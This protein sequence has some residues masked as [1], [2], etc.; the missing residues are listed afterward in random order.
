M[1]RTLI[2]VLSLAVIGTAI[3]AIVQAQEAVPVRS[4]TKSV[5]VPSNSQTEPV[6]LTDDAKT[7]SR[8]SKPISERLE[9]SRDQVTQEYA[10]AQ[11]APS[12]NDFPI[13]STEQ[14]EPGQLAAP[15]E[16]STPSVS[17]EPP[18]L[19]PPNASQSLDIEAPAAT[20]RSLSDAKTTARRTGQGS[21]AQLGDAVTGTGG[22]KGGL[23]QLQGRTALLTSQTPAVLVKAEGPSEIHVGQTAIYRI[24]VANHASE[25]IE[26][27]YVRLVLPQWIDL[28]ESKA[29]SG[30]LRRQD[31]SDGSQVLIWKVPQMESQSRSNWV[32]KIVP[33]EN[34]PFDL[35]VDWWVRP[36]SLQAG[37]RVVKPELQLAIRGPAEMTYGQSQMFT[38]SVT[39]PGNGDADNVSVSLTPGEEKPHWIGHIPAGGSRQ[40]QFEMAAAQAGVMQ[41]RAV[42]TAD[43]KL[44]ADVDYAVTVRQ[45]R[46]D[47]KVVGPARKY[48]GSAVKYQVVLTNLGDAPANDLL[49]RAALPSGVTLVPGEGQ[50]DAANGTMAWKLGT[51]A[52][53]TERKFDFTCQ[54][55]TAGDKT[56]QV[57]AEAESANM[58]SATAMTEVTGVADLKLIVND[59]QG[60]QAVGDEVVYEVQVLNRGSKTAEAVKLVAQFSDHIEPVRVSGG[61]ADLVPGQALFR[62]LQRL[63]PGQQVTLKVYAKASTTGNHRFRAELTSDDPET[64]LVQEEMTRFMTDP[65]QAAEDRTVQEED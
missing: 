12:E 9:V 15:L 37:I 30:D 60:P 1:N 6:R 45:P 35:N 49:I 34:K 8:R 25:S 58:V 10:A 5:L 28:E 21:R 57:S 3:V 20:G 62:P 48:A 55:V 24:D 46:L 51:L 54:L 16:S 11:Q 18:L 13:G 63:E 32:I 53:N 22:E 61:R 23:S 40:L 14:A 33:R 42:A 19:T 52:A 31:V 17:Q 64:Q 27:F 36:K 4:E 56:V 39:N 44:Q 7:S 41:L 38:L 2:G 59:P 26:D 43:R 65:N 50:V 47:L 29:A